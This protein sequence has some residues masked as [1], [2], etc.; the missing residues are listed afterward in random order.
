MHNL[1]DPSHLVKTFGY[2]GI[3]GT[4]FLESGVVIGF[5]LPGDSLL[6]T[7]GLLSSQHY[8]NLVG[9]IIVAVIG[10]IIG[11]NVG[12][13]T[14]RKAGPTLFT[15][16]DSWLFSHERVKEAHDFFEKKGGVALVLAR[17]IPA[18][19]TFVP[20]VA[21]VGRMDYRGFVIF[22]AL[23]G[24]LWGISM[25]VLGYTVGKTVPNI[26]SYVLPIILAIIILS[27]LPVLVHYI[28]TKRG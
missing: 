12:Y 17:F 11:N 10:A 2:L 28:R 3:L 22:N 15:R 6:F 8:L 27:A 14:G 18:V 25:P 5:F 21:G 13:Y 24:L 26:D 16:K 9:V 19:R 20:I 7:A 1:L 23:G 4:I